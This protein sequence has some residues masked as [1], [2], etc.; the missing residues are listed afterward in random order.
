M[1]IVKPTSWNKKLKK[2]PPPGPYPQSLNMGYDMY[3]YD[4]I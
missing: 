2:P 4:H 3:Q 1:Y